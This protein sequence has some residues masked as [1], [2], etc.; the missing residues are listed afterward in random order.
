M[1]YLEQ[2]KKAQTTRIDFPCLFEDGNIEA[3]FGM[4][5]PTDNGF[6]T[7]NQ[8]KAGMEIQNGFFFLMEIPEQNFQIIWAY[9][10]LLLVVQF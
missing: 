7:L 6:I 10:V 1:Q 9:V 2:L 8:Y 5:D 3:I 4:L